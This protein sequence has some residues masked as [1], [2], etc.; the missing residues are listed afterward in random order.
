METQDP[1]QVI[2]GDWIQQ[3]GFTQREN[4]VLGDKN[5]SVQA[6]F[7]Y[8]LLKMFAWQKGSAFPG[9][10]TLAELMGLKVRMVQIYL[11]ELID[12]GLVER[13]QRGLNKSNLYI[14][15]PLGA[16]YCVSDPQHITGQEVQSV[17][18][19]EVQPITHEEYAAKNTQTKKTQSVST[20]TRASAP[21]TSTSPAHNPAVTVTS[22]SR[23]MQHPQAIKR[24]TQLT[25]VMSTSDTFDAIPAA[26]A[27][28]HSDQ[29]RTA[30]C[31]L[32]IQT[33]PRRNG[34]LTDTPDNI[35]L[36]FI[37]ISRDA[38]YDV[39]RGA[40]NYAA[41]AEAQRGIVKGA[42]KWLLDK[43]W[44]IWQQPEQ[45]KTPTGGPTRGH[46]ESKGERAVRNL[47]LLA[48]ECAAEDDQ[49]ADHQEP[50]RLLA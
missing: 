32:F 42:V 36:A 7:L 38:Y 49:G 13:K 48:E 27:S 37:H 4:V 44:T 29:E 18:G 15:L 50:P 3:Q 12:A 2:H 9:Q 1:G 40:E 5:L 14:I 8:T 28:H 21:V 30:V 17:T 46:Y 23:T 35:G 47:R 20:H 45:I 22:P 16:K 34:V 10:E 11:K 43:Q 26:G 31:D 33:Y 6:R 24:A 39:I 41:S 19:Q 25:P